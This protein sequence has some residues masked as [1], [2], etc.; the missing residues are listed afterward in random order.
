MNFDNTTSRLDKHII[1]VSR[2][3]YLIEIFFYLRYLE[4]DNNE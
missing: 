2:Y 4:K 3:A 1:R